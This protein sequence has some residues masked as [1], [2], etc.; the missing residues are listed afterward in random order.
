MGVTLSIHLELPYL[1]TLKNQINLS[2]L[3][4]RV[5]ITIYLKILTYHG[6]ITYRTRR[7]ERNEFTKSNFYG[8][9]KN[10]IREI[11]NFLKSKL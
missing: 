6:D 4:F 1:M 8:Q 10:V 9:K 2:F 11:E 3:S 7:A 5:I